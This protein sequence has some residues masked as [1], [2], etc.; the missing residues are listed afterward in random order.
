M[1][2]Y[3]GE[4]IQEEENINEETY[5]S[6]SGVDHLYTIRTLERGMSHSHIES[7]LLSILFYTT[8]L[9]VVGEPFSISLFD[10]RMLS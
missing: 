10:E 2:L 9:I 8:V 1:C 7:I 5:K 4:S 6:W 3:L